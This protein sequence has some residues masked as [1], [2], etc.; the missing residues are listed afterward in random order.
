MLHNLHLKPVF[1]SF[2]L[3]S[4]LRGFIIFQPEIHMAAQRAEIRKK[5]RQPLSGKTF[6]QHIRR[7]L[8]VLSPAG[9]DL[10]RRAGCK[11]YLCTA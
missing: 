2:F 9:G 8:R 10:S 7:I 6:L 1:R 5:T 4:A 3:V 11:R